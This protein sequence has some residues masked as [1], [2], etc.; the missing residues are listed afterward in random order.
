MRST[1]QSPRAK[2]LSSRLRENPVG[3]PMR[4]GAPS[5]FLLYYPEDDRSY[6]V[7]DPNEPLATLLN[8]PDAAFRTENQSRFFRV[9][10][11]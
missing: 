8:S 4:G 2:A 6:S 11:C 9:S 7:R 3:S 10:W 5:D 1:F